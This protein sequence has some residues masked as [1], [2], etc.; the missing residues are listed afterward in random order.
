[1]GDCRTSGFFPDL[2][3]DMLEYADLEEA[4]LGVLDWVRVVG[5]GPALMVVL[6]LGSW[7]V[8]AFELSKNGGRAAMD[9]DRDGAVFPGIGI[10]VGMGICLWGMFCIGILIGM[11][12]WRAG[13]GVLGFKLVA[14]PSLRSN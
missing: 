3:L 7:P 5:T 2:L 12:N 6:R 13:E 1:M 9:D 11:T 14:R 10:C 4:E 8:L